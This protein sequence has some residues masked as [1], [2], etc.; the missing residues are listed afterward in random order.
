M[1]TIRKMTDIPETAHILTDIR[2][3]IP[4]SVTVIKKR[5]CQYDI[6]KI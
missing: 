1:R 5:L 2:K 6:N 4:Q 3:A